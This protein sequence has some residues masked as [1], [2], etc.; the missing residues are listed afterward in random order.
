[1]TNTIYG[2]DFTSNPSRSKRLTLARCNLHGDGVLAVTGLESLN[3]ATEGD[4][5]GVVSWLNGGEASGREWAAGIDFPFGLP[6]AAVE[7]FRWLDGA[8]EPTWSAMVDVIYRTCPTLTE[9]QDRIESWKRRDRK[10][11]EVKVH[12]KRQTDQTAGS[13]VSSP[14]KVRDNPPVGSMFYAGA[15]LLRHS[16]AS[17]YPVCVNDAPRSVVEAYPALVVSRFVGDRR[18]KDQSGE[19]RRSRAE[20]IRRE[21]LRQLANPNVYGVRVRFAAEDDRAACVGD[22]S[23]DRLDSVLCAVQAAWASRHGYGIPELSISCFRSTIALEGW[24]A[25]P[26]L[27]RHFIPAE[28]VS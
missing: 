25:D 16:G 6:V 2:L 22:H 11:N 5:S 21:I 27:Q 18:Y 15:S 9:F 20:D 12:I 13:A 4:F 1:M 23:G 24:I 3:T 10:N 14:L 26:A 7:H 19:E 8:S 17:V 28:D